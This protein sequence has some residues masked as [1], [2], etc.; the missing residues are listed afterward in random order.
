VGE[1][2]YETRAKPFAEIFRDGTVGA[3]PDGAVSDSGR[4]WG[5]YV[6]GLF[7]NDDFR[8]A[9]LAAARKAMD[10]APAETW[11]NVAAEREGRIDRLADHLRKSLAM[12]RVRSWITDPAKR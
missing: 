8:H 9:F 7:D 3:I 1:T 5:T 10:L 12:S 2:V 11:A 4:V 6:H